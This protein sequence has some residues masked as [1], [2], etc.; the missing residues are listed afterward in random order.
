L[1][2]PVLDLATLGHGL[3][4]TLRGTAEDAVENEINLQLRRLFK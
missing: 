2:N 3:A 4:D 1:E